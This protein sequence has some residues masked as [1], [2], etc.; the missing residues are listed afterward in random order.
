MR[1][2]QINLAVLA[3][4]ML[5][6]VAF[7]LRRQPGEQKPSRQP[8]R[9]VTS[10]ES[11]PTSFAPTPGGAP[12]AKPPPPVIVQGSP[13]TV[14]GSVKIAG[15]VPARKILK[16]DYHPDC[17]GMHAGVVMSD[18]LVVDTNGNVQW[19]FVHVKSGPIG[20]P[21]PAPTTPVLMDQIRCIF[22]PHVVGVRV[23]QP[24]R[25]L[26]SDNVLHVVHALPFTNKEFNVGLPNAG[27]D[28]ERT[29]TAPEV[30]LKIKCDVHPWM[31]SWIGVMDHPYFSITNELGSYVIRDLPPGKFTVEVWHEQYV[32]VA[33]EVQIPPG[34]DVALDFVLD[35]KK[36]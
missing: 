5:L 6:V 23:G 28:V 12:E 4:A 26:S 19:A 14:R 33:R 17:R 34:G 32:S 8:L 3:L 24:L 29:F 1:K 11:E 10:V 36:E 15:P 22:T 20:T 18:Q 21:P 30:M 16:I 7:L 13:G 35:Q 25:V 9:P 27:M 31:A 2:K